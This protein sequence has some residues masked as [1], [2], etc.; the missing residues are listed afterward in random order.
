M[1]GSLIALEHRR[2]TG[3]GQHV[4]LSIQEATSR[5]LYQITGSWDMTGRNLPRDARPN[6]GEGNLSWTWRCRDG[7][8]IWVVPIGPGSV[9]R[10]SGLFA[11]LNECGEGHELQSIDWEH[12]QVEEI[13]AKTTGNT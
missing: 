9:Q 8:V 13:T 11:W 1:I 2:Q 5:G 6:V 4:D 3:R 10:L 12:L 7:Y